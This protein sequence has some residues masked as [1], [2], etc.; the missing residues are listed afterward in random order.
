VAA[1]HVIIG[2]ELTVFQSLDGPTDR[3]A[4]GRFLIDAVAPLLALPHRHLHGEKAVME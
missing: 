3:D 2:V 1:R 4:L